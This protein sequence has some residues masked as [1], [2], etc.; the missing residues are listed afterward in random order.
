LSLSSEQ[1][2]K[3]KI[4]HILNVRWR[5]VVTVSLREEN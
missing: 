5:W 4:T 3:L 2:L 1:L